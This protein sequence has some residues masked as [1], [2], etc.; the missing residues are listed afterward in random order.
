MGSQSE[1]HTESGPAQTPAD[2]VRA[3]MVLDGAQIQKLKNWASCRCGEEV[4]A[5]YLSTFVVT[6]ALIWA[7]LLK[8]EGGIINFSPND[9]VDDDQVCY[10][11]LV[12]DCRNRCE[13]S[14]PIPS[15]YFGNCLALWFVRLKRKELVGEWGMVEA[16]KAIG[17]KIK[18][19]KRGGLISDA[20]RWMENWKE[21]AAGKSVVT[22]AGSPK[23][24]VYQTDFG[25]GRPRKSEVV[26]VERSGVISIGESREEEGGIEVGLA[27]PKLQ[28]DNFQSILKQRLEVEMP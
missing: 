10:F 6:C 24:G 21:A 13:F 1:K 16:A 18:E 20:E 12:A 8:S 19:M 3:T 17:K 27:L 26:H 22:V 4:D 9:D 14:I 2:K 11:V 23:L 7:C 28:M 5:T 25:W 15:T